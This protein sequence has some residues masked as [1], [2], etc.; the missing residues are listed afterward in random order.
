MQNE[1]DELEKMIG[2]DPNADS[3]EI[4]IEPEPVFEEE[5]VQT[6]EIDYQEPGEVAEI[7]SGETIKKTMEDLYQTQISH[8]GSLEDYLSTLPRH[9]ADRL[10]QNAID[11]G[12][13]G[14]TLL[15]QEFMMHHA[16]QTQANLLVQLGEQEK[17][18]LFNTS[19]RFSRIITNGIEAKANKKIEEISKEFQKGGNSIRSL[20]KTLSSMGQN[21]VNA[22]KNREEVAIKH[23]ADIEEKMMEKLDK[24]IDETNNIYRNDLMA[25]IK[26]D[27][28]DVKKYIIEGAEVAFKDIVGKLVGWY[29]IKVYAIA[30]FGT[31]SALILCKLCGVI[32]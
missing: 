25:H 26:K 6:G 15:E 14:H 20:S 23:Y 3:V 1:F 29:L 31:L 7:N 12:I 19:V 4:E 9:E 28:G 10:R 11:R 16:S 24:K 17:Q 30:F 21:L 27:V 8:M 22:E 32:H 2:N 5:F 18:E 13:Y